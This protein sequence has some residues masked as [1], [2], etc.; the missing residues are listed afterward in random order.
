M[1]H[2]VIHYYDA[3]PVTIAQVRDITTDHVWKWLAAGWKDIQT[4]PA[5]SLS[6]G[7]GLMIV[8]YLLT[9]SV[10][11]SGMYILLPLL[12]AGFFMV[13][14]LLGIGLYEISRQLEQGE[15]PTLKSTLLAVRSNSFNLLNMGIILVVAL[16]A[17]VTVAQ[18]VVALT[19]SG[20]TPATWQGFVSALF[21][22]WEGA[23]LLAVGI[24]CG[25][26]IAFVIF[27]ISAVSVPML[28]DRSNNVFD[29]IQT[30]W[31]S[32]RYNI[33]PML[34][35]A[36]ILLAIITAGFLTLYVGLVIGFPLA[37][38]ATWHAY[39]DLVGEEEPVA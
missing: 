21:G 14:P 9:L 5:M 17:W 13:A 36:A 15:I 18:L 24:S 39:R 22:T 20:I 27:S 26:A 16:I 8:S 23:Q 11:A 1:Y 6:Y 38:H 2:A 35:W 3:R 7:L 28:L 31:N 4:A 12:L 34:L 32:V 25:A 10:I 19:F 30:S 29:A 33:L 37:A